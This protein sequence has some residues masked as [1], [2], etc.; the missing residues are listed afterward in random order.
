MAKPEFLMLSHKYESRR[1]VAGFYA[2]EKLDGMRCYWDGGVSRGAPAKKVPW[3]NCAKHDRFQNEVMATGLWTRYA[4]PIQ[5]PSAWLD[6]LPKAVPLD[7]ELWMGEGKFQDVMSVCK[8]IVPDN[9]R[10]ENVK[11]FVF[12]LPSWKN[13]YSSR[14]VDNPQMCKEI[15]ASRC[16]LFLQEQS[17]CLLDQSE[18]NNLFHPPVDFRD[19]QNP[20]NR[21]FTENQTVKLLKQVKLPNSEK[22]AV[23]ELEIMLAEIESRGGEGIMLRRPVS[24]WKPERSWDLLKMKRRHDMEVTVVGYTWGRQTDKGSKLLG[25]MGAAICQMDDGKIFELSGFT[26]EERTLRCIPDRFEDHN[27]DGGVSLL[28]SLSEKCAGGKCQDF[29]EAV[30][31]PRGTKITIRY[32]ELTV[33]GLPKE[34]AYFRKVSNA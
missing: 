24:I 19:I 1:S 14:L 25:K 26:D 8:S 32:R 30:H 21:H 34:A 27:E 10:W 13:I 3:A 18:V 33:T 22:A 2:S 4:Q 31:F 7:G 28:E 20:L 11:Y 15:V 12:D 6:R 9:K 17:N 23:V 16:L 29:I 5:A